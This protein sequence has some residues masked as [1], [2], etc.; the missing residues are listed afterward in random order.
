MAW[1]R[2]FMEQEE[3]EGGEEEA[4]AQVCERFGCVRGVV[5]TPEIFWSRTALKDR[6]QGPPIANHQPPTA[7][8]CPPPTA[9]NRHQPPIAANHQPPTFEVEKVPM[10][11][12]TPHPWPWVTFA[13]S[14]VVVST[15]P[16]SRL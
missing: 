8:N 3:E 16:I 11:V 7:I 1:I 2:K 6:P 5:R 13:T 9:A 15:L 10:G 12:C 4:K 14:F